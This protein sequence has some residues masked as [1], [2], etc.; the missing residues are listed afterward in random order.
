MIRMFLCAIFGL[1]VAENISTLPVITPFKVIQKDLVPILKTTGSVT[2]FNGAILSFE[3]SGVIDT[4]HVQAGQNVM[5]GDILLQLDASSQEANLGT[6]KTAYEK[7]SIEY[8]RQLSLFKSNVISQETLDR[9]IVNLSDAESNLVAAKVQVDNRS[10]KAP[11]NGQV[12]VVNVNVGQFTQQ[13]Q[14]IVSLQDLSRM[15]VMFDVDQSDA[16]TIKKGFKFD[17]KSG[18]SVGTGTV[19]AIDTVVDPS[20]GQVSVQGEFT[21]ERRMFLSGQL[22]ETNIFLNPLK[23]QII[24][25]L[26]AVNFRLSG[27]Y[28]YVIDDIKKRDGKSV[29]LVKQQIIELGEQNN[30]DVVVKSGLNPGQT[31]VAVGSNKIISS[32]SAVI[33][34]TQTKLPMENG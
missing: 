9:Y 12:G 30:H 3:S 7:A 2:A 10:L 23:N 27:N 19:T 34:D 4:I 17:F 5:E 21:N 13:G 20:S 24:I 16:M 29:G 28:V 31:I 32:G 18:S 6:A 11:Y 22:G 33:I 25:P 15:R 1:A 8:K 14:G 26:I